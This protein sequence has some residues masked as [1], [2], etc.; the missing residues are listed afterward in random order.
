MEELQRP[1]RTAPSW[2]PLAFS[3]VLI[4]GIILGRQFAGVPDVGLGFGM[5]S[6]SALS[7]VLDRVERMYVDP[8]I[9]AEL[10]QI[11][12]EAVLERLDPHS[13]FISSEELAEL[14]EPMEGNFEGIGVEFIIQND[15]LMVVAAIPG[16][17]AERAGIRA[18]DRIVSVDSLDISGPD[19]TNRRVMELLK[20]PRG[21][22]V[23]VGLDRKD[24]PKKVVLERDRIPI[25]SVVCSAN[26]DGQRGYIK[27]VRFAQN[28]AIEFDQA[29]QALS[30]QG[31]QEVIIDLR[32][33]GGGYLNAVVPMVESFL[34]KDQLVVYTEGEHSARRVYAASRNGQWKDW[35]LVVLV[36]E[37]S[38]SASEIFAGAIQDHDRG[39]VIGRRTFGKGLVQEEFSIDELGALRLTVARFYTPT[40]RAIQRP[41][42]EGIDYS[43]DYFDRY[44][45]GELFHQDSIALADSLLYQTPKGKWVHGGGGITPD[46]FLPLDT[47][48]LSGYLSELS[49]SGVLRDAAFSFVDENRDKVLSQDQLKSKA[50]PWK[51]ESLEFL[52]QYAEQAGLPQEAEMTDLEEDE[53]ANRMLAQIIRNID[54]ESSY[55][56]YLATEDP[57]VQEAQRWLKNKRNIGVVNG[58]LTLSPSE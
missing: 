50:E 42:G 12:L 57:A 56:E 6:K 36:D 41:Y 31:L 51:K 35:D 45:S 48:R 3:V 8:V 2:Q 34:E 53:L 23:L 44:E 15:T 21:T 37:S 1:N 26:L 47:A 9:R 19:L 24:G 43:S 55:Y 49:W 18:G 17:P 27:V 5:N 4:L 13:V 39:P 40:G 22:Q 11:A 16:G 38:A 20:G 58:R 33:N 32:G 30:Q 7:G 10:E 54:G 14:A 46:V 28:T 52:L 29:M 25:H